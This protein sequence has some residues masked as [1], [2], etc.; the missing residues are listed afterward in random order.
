MTAHFTSNRESMESH[1]I[2]LSNWLNSVDL[3]DAA[4][5]L[6]EYLGDFSD[7]SVVQN[8]VEDLAYQERDEDPNNC[9]RLVD[10]ILAIDSRLNS[11]PGKKLLKIL[12]ESRKNSIASVEWSSPVDEVPE[13]MT[14]FWKTG[15]DRADVGSS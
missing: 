12:H 14:P 10:T 7:S 6:R 1:L 3:T 15:C 13:N 4:S 8:W 2:Q 11:S 9:P 5:Y